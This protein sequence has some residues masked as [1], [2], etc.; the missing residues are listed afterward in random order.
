[1]QID[2]NLVEPSKH[3][4]VH[5]PFCRSKCPYCDFYSIPV[6]ASESQLFIDYLDALASEISEMREFAGVLSTIY[7]G[8]GT[9]S[10]I[11]ATNLQTLMKLIRGNFELDENAEITVEANPESFDAE[12]AEASAKS[13]INRI[14]I[15]AQSFNVDNLRFLG[16]IHDSEQIYK[17][18]ECI[19]NAGF[20][21]FNIDLITALPKQAISDVLHDLNEA[22]SL[23]PTHL[24]VYN[25]I[26][27]ENTPFETCQ[28]NR[29]FEMA[30]AEEISEIYDETSK[31]LSG[32]DFIHYEIS[33]FA[34]QGFE[35]QHN[36]GYW[37]YENYLGIGASAQSFLKPYRFANKR[38][39]SEYLHSERREFVE[40][41]TPTQQLDETLLLGLRTVEGVP[42]SRIASLFSQEQF[43]EKIHKNTTILDKIN[44][45]DSRIVI[46][47]EF[48]AVADAIIL[49]IASK[50]TTDRD[51]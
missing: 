25:L 23:N 43:L 37:R 34:M 46:K 35:S 19:K 7:I 47:P 16:R 4:Y 28:K 39:L 49:S 14:S 30:D 10:V 27:E 42:I 31:H 1:M 12:F 11:G 18:A 48:F 9:P 44:I 41:L 38:N 2:S 51:S 24:S 6:D 3:L 40:I 13:G 50:L 26:I 36:L 29:E 17:A 20:R 33:N 22:L 8:G 32:K 45:S 5:V 21:N 15:G